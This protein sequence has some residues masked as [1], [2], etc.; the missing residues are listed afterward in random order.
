MGSRRSFPEHALET[1]GHPSDGD[2]EC[3]KSFLEDYASKRLALPNSGWGTL[4]EIVRDL[5][6]PRSH[7][8]GNRDTDEPMGDNSS[9]FSNPHWWST[10]YFQEKKGE[11]ET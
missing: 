2:C 6:M 11:E 7:V 5:K 1:N 8:Y 4:M 9:R 10:E 3:D